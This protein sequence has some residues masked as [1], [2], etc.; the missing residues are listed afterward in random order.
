MRTIWKYKL[1]VQVEQTISLPIGSKFLYCANQYDYPTMWFEVEPKERMRIVTIVI[2]G[3]GN[4]IPE[5]VE[6]YGTV[7]INDF[8]WHLYSYKRY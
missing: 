5:N 3:T 4:P 1:D 8:V 6:Y 2:V 7:F